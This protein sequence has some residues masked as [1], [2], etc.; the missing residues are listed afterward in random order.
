LLLLVSLPILAVHR[1]IFRKYI[2]LLVR[3]FQEE[4]LLI[5]PTGA[6]QPDAEEIEFTTTHGLVLQGCYLPTHQPRK[7]VILFGLEYGSNR[8]ACVPYC[9]FLRDQGYD[10]FAFETRGQGKSPSHAGYEPLVWITDFEVEDYR[11]AVAYLKQRADAPARGIGFFGLSKGGSAGLYVA[12]DDPW[13]RCCV[14]DGIYATHTTMVPYMQKW[15]LIY[16]KWK[17]AASRLPHWYYR[18][19]A[20]AGLRKTSEERHCS[21]PHLEWQI[22]RLAPRPLFMIHGEADNYIK[23]D[24][25]QA[26]FD[27]AGQPKE[28]WIVEGAKHNQA[29][30][31]AAAAYKERILAF[32]DKHLAEQPRAEVGGVQHGAARESSALAAAVP[33]VLASI[34]SSIPQN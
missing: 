12:C 8:W 27:R 17:K 7:G 22:Q 1:H 21:F 11:A 33:C 3:I 26:L 14:T 29:I 16:S 5:M 2:P 23:P 24:M 9:E 28:L 4:P 30:H 31:Q 25:A 13:I 32:F 20:M 18:Y 15:I 6:P 34:S 19:A 10:I